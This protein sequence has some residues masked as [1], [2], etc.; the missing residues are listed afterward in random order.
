MKPADRAKA[1]AQKA[2]DAEDSH[3]VKPVAQTAADPAEIKQTPRDRW[4]VYLWGED[5]PTLVLLSEPQTQ[6]QMRELYP[7]AAGIIA[8]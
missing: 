3:P 1:I 7:N 6:R 8:P 2:R 4:T 5:H